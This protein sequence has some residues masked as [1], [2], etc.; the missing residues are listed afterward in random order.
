MA[1]KETIKVKPLTQKQLKA[2]RGGL[3]YSYRAPSRLIPA[4][5]FPK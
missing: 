3:F 5:V 1:K 4:R 2:L